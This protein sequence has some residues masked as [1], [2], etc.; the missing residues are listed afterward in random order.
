MTEHD[1]DL[2]L[3]NAAENPALLAAAQALTDDSKPPALTNPLDGP[4]TLP[5]GFRRVKPGSDGTK[6]ETVRSAWVRELNGEDEERIARAKMRS[7]F[8][9]YIN[10]ILEAGVERLGEDRPTREDFDSLVVG[11]QQFLLVEIARATYG[12]E[13]EY[14]DFEC[15]HC[16]Q[17][18]SFSL[19]IS[20][21]IPITRL[22][23]VEDATFD[24]RLRK[25]RVATVSLPTGEVAALMS[26][27]ETPAESNTILITHCVDE[28]RGPQGTT[29]IK[30]QA[31]AAKRLGVVD[32]RDLVEALSKRM[33]GPQYNEIKFKH[34]PGCGEEIRLSV[35][36]GDL[37]L[38]L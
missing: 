14:E 18:F 20:D 12:D 19:S 36:L 25:D 15:P 21:D 30:G 31:D 6:F 26:E 23:K 8:P 4:V 37:F 38:G 29:E 5:A 28:I 32:R 2:E 22:D 16:A 35:T 24:V 13:M 7:N 9:A 27:A 11:D 34:D 1:A 17:K 3:A 33:P 10:A